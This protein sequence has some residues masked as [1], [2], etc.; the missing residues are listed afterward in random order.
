MFRRFV[1]AIAV[2]CLLLTAGGGGWWAYQ[3]WRRPLPAGATPQAA[4]QSA[5]APSGKIIVSE[6]AQKNLA[7]AAKP[8]RAQ[9]FWKSITVPG[10]I[11]DRPGL[12]DREIVA[13]VAGVVSQ[14]LHVPGDTVRP[15]DKLFTLRLASE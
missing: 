11:V 1:I 5:S 3:H 4:A 15:G 6:Q 12:S 13:P 14:L 10:M 2:L 8:L 9:T 7:L